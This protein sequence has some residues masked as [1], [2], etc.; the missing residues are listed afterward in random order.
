MTIKRMV[1]AKRQIIGY[2]VSIGTGN[3]VVS[4]HYQDR[5]GEDEELNAVHFS[6]RLPM[7]IKPAVIVSTHC[8]VLSLNSLVHELVDDEGTDEGDGGYR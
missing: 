2:R 6:T 3:R 1:R 8:L 4:A 5:Y 7:S